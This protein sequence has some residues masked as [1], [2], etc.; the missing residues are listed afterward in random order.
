MRSNTFSALHT[1]LSSRV[2]ATLLEHSKKILQVSSW[3]S[4]KC[5]KH[6]CILS[7]REFAISFQE[8]LEIMHFSRQI[9]QLR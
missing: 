5:V 2:L 7:S 3:A 6:N 9:V 4:Y 1:K 8:Q